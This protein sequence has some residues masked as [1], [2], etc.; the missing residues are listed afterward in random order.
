MKMR[1]ILFLICILLNNMV[2]SKEYHCPKT[3][4]QIGIGEIMVDN[5]F[6]WPSQEK[7]Y[8]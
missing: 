1:A 3:P 4:I 6:V 8:I 5:W 2:I 7:K